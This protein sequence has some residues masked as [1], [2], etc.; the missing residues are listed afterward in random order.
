MTL[1]NKQWLYFIRWNDKD[2]YEEKVRYVGE[3]LQNGIPNPKWVRTEK[4]KKVELKIVEITS[5]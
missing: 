4:M 1:C 5:A 2:Y 3:I